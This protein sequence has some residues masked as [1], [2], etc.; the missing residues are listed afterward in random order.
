MENTSIHETLS[1]K[2]EI[3]SAE[4][5]FNWDGHVFLKIVRMT[6]LFFLVCYAPAVWARTGLAAPWHYGCG[7]RFNQVMGAGP[8]YYCVG[9]AAGRPCLR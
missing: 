4:R 3:T 8:G 6:L 2:T 5:D 7:L 1:H 9:P